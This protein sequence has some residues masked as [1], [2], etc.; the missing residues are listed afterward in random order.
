M[1]K[2]ASRLQHTSKYNCL[3]IHQ[4]CSIDRRTEKK[5]N[6]IFAILFR[7]RL[8]HTYFRHFLCVLIHH[9]LCS[10]LNFDSIFN[11]QFGWNF[12]VWRQLKTRSD[13]K[14]NW[15][16]SF[17]ISFLWKFTCLH[18][19]RSM[20]HIGILTVSFWIPSVVSFVFFFCVYVHLSNEDGLSDYWSFLHLTG[21]SIHL[22][23]DK[24]WHL[25]GN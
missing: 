6:H 19:W 5:N 4:V 13:W 9:N 8:F 20:W 22:A 23:L 25:K 15:I 7:V 24:K 1:R 10:P 14:I 21:A 12:I 2:C 17:R 11:W 18:A 3:I 16:I